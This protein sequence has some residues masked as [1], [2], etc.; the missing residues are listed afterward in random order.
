MAFPSLCQ[1]LG[2]L[3]VENRHSGAGRSKH[4]PWRGRSTPRPTSLRCRRL[5]SSRHSWRRPW[6][7]KSPGK[8]RRKKRRGIRT[9]AKMRGDPRRRQSGGGYRPTTKLSYDADPE[10][11]IQKP[12]CTRFQV[13]V[14][15]LNWRL[16]EPL[17]QK[18]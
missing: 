11:F 13:P 17:P 7:P 3:A 2:P 15:H 9:H 14:F 4:Q 12:S 5:G 16:T 8:K 6:K 18:R 10:S 1:Y